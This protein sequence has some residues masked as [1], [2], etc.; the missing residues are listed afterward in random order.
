MLLVTWFNGVAK[1][2]VSFISS[3]EIA[4]FIV[5]IYQL[6]HTGLTQGIAIHT[7]MHKYIKL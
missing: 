2:P 4:I 3:P 7:C 5:C 1:F 6:Y